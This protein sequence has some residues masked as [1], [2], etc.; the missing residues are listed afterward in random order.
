MSARGTIPAPTAPFSDWPARRVV[1]AEPILDTHRR[2]PRTLADAFADVRAPAI[3]APCPVRRS[4]DRAHRV[5]YV[6]GAVVL[7]T[8][9]GL[10]Y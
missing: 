2:Y 6:L 8:L 5:V 7:V 9:L 4:F 1:L 10:F 3:E